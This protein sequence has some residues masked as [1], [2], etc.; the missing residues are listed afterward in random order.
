VNGREGRVAGWIALAATVFFALVCVWEIAGPLPGGHLGNA[1]GTAIAGENMVRWHIFAAVPEYT[2]QKP[3]EALYY[4]HHPYGSFLTS[5]I[6]HALFGRGWFTVRLPAV[7]M[8]ILT[9]PL[10]F[11]TG[12]R[13]W[14][15]VGG[16]AAA[17]AFVVIPVDLAFATFHNLEVVTI[18]FGALFSW[19]TIG[20]FQT[21]RS[22]WLIPSTVGALGACHGDWVGLMLVGVVGIFAFFRAYVLPPRAFGRIAHREHARWFAFTTAAAVGTLLLYLVLFARAGKLGDLLGSYDL[23]STGAEAPLAAVFGERRR[24][25]VLWMLPAIALAGVGMSLAFS[26]IGLLRGRIDECVPLAWIAA[27]SFQYFV[28]RQGAD[29][30]IF[31]PHYYG[32]VAA[33][34]FGA[35]APN[36]LRAAKNLC[37]AVS[38]SWHRWAAPLSLAPFGIALILLLRVGLVLLGQSR[39][40]GGRFD[41]GGRYIAVDQDRNEFAAWA[42]HDVP[43]NTSVG[44]H[45]SFVRSWSVD[46]AMGRPAQ[47]FNGLPSP[48]GGDAAIVLADARY[49]TGGEVRAMAE[50]F[51]VV[52]A[53]PYLRF[54]RRA[55]PTPFT[56][57]SYVERQPNIL[58]RYFITGSDLVRTIG[59]GVD[60]LATWEW[61]DHTGQPGEPPRGTAMTPE[62]ARILHNAAIARGD[63]QEA[64]RLRA[65]AEAG[66]RIRLDRRFS[67]D[68]TLLGADVR[69]GAAT[70]VTLLWSTG[71]AFE[72]F[73]EDFLVRTHVT[74][75]PPIW[76]SKTDF[77]EK[78][79]APPMALRSSLWKPRHLY[80]QTFVAMRRVGTEVFEG[81]WTGRSSSCPKADDGRDRI[82]L[83]TLK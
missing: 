26:A 23:R 70:V 2:L 51:A 41:D 39:L 16:A 38:P 5:A 24:M 63:D 81:L 83:F 28:F 12:R 65:Q 33:F 22:R 31:W 3:R 58:E 40:T 9:P 37:D 57:L 25:W 35:A 32:V 77:F 75:P 29:V 59:P 44:L 69:E 73:D 71:P 80:A 34:G 42:M 15:P 82:V 27:A 53:G 66:I 18:F 4:T 68:V 7:V 67:R 49:L 56:A 20:L 17:A 11:L 48:G 47:A 1:A 43:R 54:D 62:Q 74:A 21:F 76:L 72:A 64:G 10:L 78:E 13:L 61:R 79:M 50:R 6:A 46:Y 45:R 19:G 14:G 8:S 30:H 60:P 36:A 55:A 52:A